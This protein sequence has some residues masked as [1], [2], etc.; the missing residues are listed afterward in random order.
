MYV[1]NIA[2]GQPL[3][4]YTCGCLVSEVGF[5]H[6]HRVLDMDVLIFVQEGTLYITK[7]GTEFVVN[8][9]EYILLEA[10]SEHW[11][12]NAKRGAFIYVGA[13]CCA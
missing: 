10:G 12:K 3:C 4:F 11:D 2:E 7:D 9:D 1:K 8:Q 6:V 13:F 5:I